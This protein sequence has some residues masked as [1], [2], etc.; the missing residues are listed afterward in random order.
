M[1]IKLYVAVFGQPECF[2]GLAGNEFYT[3]DLVESLPTAHF[4]NVKEQQQK[5][6]V[7]IGFQ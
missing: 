5:N 1:L 2:V 3:P 6:F 7:S 4:M